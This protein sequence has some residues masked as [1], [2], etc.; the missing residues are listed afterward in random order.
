MMIEKNGSIELRD[1]SIAE[2]RPPAWCVS[3]TCTAVR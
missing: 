3:S 2:D 1:I